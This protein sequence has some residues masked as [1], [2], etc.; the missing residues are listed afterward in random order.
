MEQ[1]TPTEPNKPAPKSK[2]RGLYGAELGANMLRAAAAEAIGTFMLVFIGTGV[3]TAAS[4]DRAIA[5]G[6]LNSLSVGL[7]FGVAL[8]ALVSALGHV[9]GAHF[10]PAVT[11]ALAATKN[12]PWKYVP[13]YLGAQLGGACAASA[14]VWVVFGDAGN[15]VAHLAATSPGAGVSVL[16]AFT[17]ETIATFFLVLVVVSVATDE[18][19]PAA[20]AAPAVGFAL[21]AAV[22]LGGPVSGGAINPARAFGPMIVSAN[23][24]SAWWVY[25]VAPVLGAVV[26]AFFYA[27]FIKDAAAPAG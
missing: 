25:A 1:R 3:A 4:L 5:G 26:A 23:F 19:V 10:N 11:L 27:K 18:R 15:A 21:A 2:S 7:A 14:A 20:A 22:L 12:F 6:A 16:Q 13:S 9:S 24:P 8:I 17:V